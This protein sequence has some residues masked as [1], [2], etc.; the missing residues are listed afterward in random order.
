MRVGD[1]VTLSSAGVKSQQNYEVV[2]KIGLLVAISKD[3]Y[4]FKVE[5]FG[6]NS[7]SSLNREESLRYGTGAGSV[8]P[9]KRYEIKQVK[10]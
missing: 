10:K 7:G 4:P 3:A 6:C 2:G 1:L 8:L 5:W 9:M